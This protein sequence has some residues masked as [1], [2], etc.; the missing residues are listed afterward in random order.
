MRLS[1]PFSS[2][3]MQAVLH[4]EFVGPKSD[5]LLGLLDQS[6]IGSGNTPQRTVIRPSTSPRGVRDGS[7]EWKNAA[8]S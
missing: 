4:Q 8:R 2:V 5:R 7:S 3:L 1:L 6:P